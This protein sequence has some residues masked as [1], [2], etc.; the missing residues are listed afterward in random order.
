MLSLKLDMKKYSHLSELDIKSIRA[1]TSVAFMS[2]KF[3]DAHLISS[4]S[5]VDILIAILDKCKKDKVSKLIFSKGHGAPGLYAVL[6][7]LD[8]IKHAELLTFN[9]DNS[10]LGIH[11]SSHLLDCVE[12]STGSLGHGLGVGGGMALANKLSRVDSTT[13]VVLGDGE[14]NEGSIWEAALFCATNKLDNLI[15]IVDHNRV[16]SIS[17]YSEISNGT[18]LSQKFASFGFD[19]REVKG[20]SQVELENAILECSKIRDKPHVII[21]QTFLEPRVKLFQSEVSWHYKKPTSDE[22]EN[23][24]EE[25]QAGIYCTDIVELFK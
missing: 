16:Q 15:V 9:S 19:S 3:G 21:A 11:S 13:F 14:T 22:L 5:C 7:E 6:A 23:A 17:D 24:L 18:Q 25:L 20:H 1:A 10:R 4:I 12:L 8:F 2:Y